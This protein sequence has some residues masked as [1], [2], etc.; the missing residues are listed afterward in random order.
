MA[1]MVVLIWFEDWLGF[2]GVLGMATF[3]SMLARPITQIALEGSPF[4]VLLGAWLV[5]DV[6]AFLQVLTAAY[7][8]VP[9]GMIMREK[10]SL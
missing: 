8:F 4:K 10:T 5:A 3:L 7:A 1:S 2:I 9:G 6:L